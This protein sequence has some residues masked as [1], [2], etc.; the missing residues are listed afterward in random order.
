MTDRLITVMDRWC[1]NCNLAGSTPAVCTK[2][3]TYEI[4]KRESYN[5]QDD[6]CRW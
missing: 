6:L 1:I 5:N 4:K 3:K 2:I